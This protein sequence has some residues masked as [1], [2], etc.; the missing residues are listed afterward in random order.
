MTGVYPTERLPQGVG[1]RL[2][3]YQLEGARTYLDWILPAVLPENEDILKMELQ[4]TAFIRNQE[5]A[6]REKA[7]RQEICPVEL[8][9]VS[10]YELGFREQAEEKADQLALDVLRHWNAEQIYHPEL[11][12]QLDAQ[13]TYQ[14]LYE[15]E[16]KMQ[17]KFSV[18]ELKKMAMY[19]MEEAEE[20]G[21]VL[22]PEPE[23]VPL[24]PAFV[25]DMEKAAGE[26]REKPTGLT[27]A[28]RGSAYHKLMELL[29]FTK[30]Y[31]ETSL[32]EYIHLQ[33]EVGK[34]TEE[35]ASCIRPRD[36]LQF[37]HSSGGRRMTRAAKAGKLYKEQPFVLGIDAA[38]IYPGD[39]SGE[40][41]LVQ[42]IID[43][44]FEE[45]GE[46]VVLDYKTDKVQKAAELTERY[47]A[48]LEYYAQAL[49][50][51]LQKPVKE[52]IIYSFTLKEEISL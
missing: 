25:S 23:I 37:L 36:I 46:L 35:M 16:G 11:R 18:S 13:M 14:Y 31:D 38:E 9:I 30:D 52:K 33:R 4:R 44:F 1:G 5:D 7:L 22:Y 29:D 45:D 8:R 28:S 34:L 27:G 40:K 20:V 21:E 48:Q 19:D 3:F 47:H 42:G 10:A 12:E 15:N 26:C 49:E 17:M 32:T 6:D 24:I 50:Q 43:V 2:G 39:T 41:I 51:L